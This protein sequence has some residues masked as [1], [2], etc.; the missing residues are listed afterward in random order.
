M[1]ASGDVGCWLGSLPGS[2]H[3]FHGPHD[4]RRYIP[5]DLARVILG[6]HSHVEH[7]LPHFHDIVLRVTESLLAEPGFHCGLKVIFLKFRVLF[8]ALPDQLLIPA[9]IAVIVVLHQ[10]CV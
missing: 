9:L 8:H 10:G 1:G 4:H 2:G 6:H 3:F 7:Q 5:S